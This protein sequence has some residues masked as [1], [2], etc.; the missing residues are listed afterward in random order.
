MEMEKSF[1]AGTFDPGEMLKVFVRYR[2][3][4]LYP[5]L[6]LG[7]LA[8]VISFL[9]P[10]SY[11]ATLTA[12]P[13]EVAGAGLFGSGGPSLLTK[14]IPS[15]ALQAI[16]ILKSREIKEKA[17]DRF[18]L[19][20]L[21]GVTSRKKAL[22]K[23]SRDLR[24][25]YDQNAGVIK[26]EVVSKDPELAARVANFVVDQAE[27]INERLQVFLRKPM[28]RVVDKA[29]PPD[30]KYRPRRGVNTAA[31]LVVGFFL[32]LLLVFARHSFDDRLYDAR[33]A[34]RALP[35]VE[36][37]SVVPRLKGIDPLRTSDDAFPPVGLLPFL[38]KVAEAGRG[39]FAFT[40]PRGKEGKTF[41]ALCAGRYLA[42]NYEV[43]LIDANPTS[44]GITA[45]T[46]LRGSRGL[47]DMGGAESLKELIAVPEGFSFRVLP[48]GQGE[49]VDYS[50]LASALEHFTTQFEFVLLELP[51][52]LVPGFPVEMLKIPGDILLVLRYSRSKLSDLREIGLLFG[53]FRD[54]FRLVLDDYDEKIHSL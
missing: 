17:I 54:R 3:W 40:G 46:G 35:D 19:D 48:A 11:K 23:F 42:R 27:E 53:G 37:F 51:G 41:L 33:S 10:N 24:V 47:S 21:Y 22:R 25:F 44:R 28:L 12:L 49:K 43:L 16:A 1:E 30:R 26:V 14:G 52:M 18:R 50:G 13:P 31:G 29:I 36:I 4:W 32:G 5:T 8:L 39:L 34:G 45:L 6:L 7:L 20:T 2:A 38:E 9:T 15:N